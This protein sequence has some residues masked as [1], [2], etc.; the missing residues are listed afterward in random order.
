[1]GP[2]TKNPDGS[3]L[4]HEPRKCPWCDVGVTDPA[5][6]VCRNCGGPLPPPTV[7][8]VGPAPPPPVD[9]GL[10]PA[11]PPRP[12]PKQYRNRV[13]YWGN[14]HT[15]IG[16][17]FTLVFFWTIVFPIIGIFLWKHGKKRAEREL[18]ALEYGVPVLGQLT[19]V[20][21]DMSQTINNRHPWIVHYAFMT[22]RG[23]R[24]GTDQGWEPSNVFRRPG[25]PVWVVYLDDDPDCSAIW[26]PVR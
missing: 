5:R 15:L 18:R 1:M 10:A 8:P 7:R 13:L 3:S 11:P 9:P 2:D 22:P 21:Q 19:G 17:I 6:Q 14:V 24:Q 25:D 4:R 23:A 16:M 12:I 20:A 26:P